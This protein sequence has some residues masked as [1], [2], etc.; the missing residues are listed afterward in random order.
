MHTAVIA[1]ALYP[2]LKYFSLDAMP[3]GHRIEPAGRHTVPGDVWLTARL[4]EL[5]LELLGV[6]RITE[7]AGLF[8]LAGF[9]PG[10]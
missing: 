7:V 6:M 4:L 8:R 10:F 5:Q 1:W 2:A 9:M 3:A